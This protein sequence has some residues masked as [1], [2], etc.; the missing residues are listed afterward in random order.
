[1]KIQSVFDASFAPYGKVI[2]GF[3]LAALA[4]E[5]EKTPCPAG[6]VVYVP[7]VEELEAYAAEGEL[8]PTIAKVFSIASSHLSTLSMVSFCVMP[9]MAP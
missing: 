6:S 4:A 5:M 3:D 2:K 7:S 1:M 8:Q 9:P